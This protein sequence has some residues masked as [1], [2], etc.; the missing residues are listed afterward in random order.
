MPIHVW[1][2]LRGIVQHHEDDAWFHMN[3]A[4]GE[5]SWRLTMICRDVLPDDPGFRPSFLGHILVELLLDA[6]LAKENP[7][8]LESYYSSLK[9]IDPMV[10][11][12]AVNRMTRN[13]CNDWVGSS[14]SSA[15]FA[16]CGITPTMNDCYSD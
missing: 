7:H 16:F 11:E 8:A 9:A 1:R 10:V 3:D 4:F 2:P 14:A 5:L 12:H 15:R 13:P 6:A